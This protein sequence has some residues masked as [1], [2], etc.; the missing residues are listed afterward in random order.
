MSIMTDTTECILVSLIHL[1]RV[2]DHDQVVDRFAVAFVLV[3]L[4]SVWYGF[5]MLWIDLSSEE[6]DERNQL[7]S[8]VEDIESIYVQP[9]PCKVRDGKMVWSCE[10]T[11]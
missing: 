10:K 11:C 1:S 7:C 3:A 6:S 5:G 4:V 2:S 8:E 9:S